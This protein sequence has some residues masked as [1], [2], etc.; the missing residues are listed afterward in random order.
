MIG[1]TRRRNMKKGRRLL[2][3][4]LTFLF[5]T[6]LFTAV[7]FADSY[8]FKVVGPSEEPVGTIT[9]TA[10]DVTYDGQA[11]M[12]TVSNTIANR[13]LTNWDD[14]IPTDGEYSEGTRTRNPNAY[15]YAI[16]PVLYAETASDGLQTEEAPVS[17]GSYSATVTVYYLN[18]QV[19]TSDPS[20]Y[21]YGWLPVGSGTIGFK[22]NKKTV[23]VDWDTRPLTYDGTKQ[24][25]EASYTNAEGDEIHLVTDTVEGDAGIRAGNHR[26]AAAF[27]AEDENA[28]NYLLKNSTKTTN[29][30][31]DPLEVELRWYRPVYDPATGE[32]VTSDGAVELQEVEEDETIGMVYNAREQKPFAEV[33]NAVTREGSTDREIVNVIVGVVDGKTPVKA[34]QYDVY[35]SRL[36]GR[37]SSNYVLSD[38][39]R[40]SVRDFE[41]IPRPVR[42]TWG[43]NSEGKDKKANVTD[44]ARQGYDYWSVYNGRTQAAFIEVG[45]IPEDEDGHAA[46][47]TAAPE[48]GSRLDYFGEP[49]KREYIDAGRYDLTPGTLSDKRNFTYHSISQNTET[50]AIAADGALPENYT[51]T[52]SIV[53]RP[54]SFRWEPL[55]FTYDGQHRQ[56]SAAVTN[57]QKNDDGE[58]DVCTVTDYVLAEADD[59]GQ[60]KFVEKTGDRQLT[61]DAGKYR[62]AVIHLSNRNYSFSDM[63]K[64]E[65]GRWF[66]K[67]DEISAFIDAKIAE[68]AWDKHNWPQTGYRIFA[69]PA[70]IKWTPDARELTYDANR[71]EYSAEVTNLVKKRQDT[72][73]ADVVEPEHGG[74]Y[75]EANAGSYTAKVEDLLGSD[76]LSAKNYTL[77]A[78]E[79]DGDDTTKVKD[80]SIDWKINKKD[81]TVTVY[82]KTGYYGDDPATYK[83]GVRYTGLVNGDANKDDENGVP[84]TYDA[85]Q[86]KDPG[87]PKV[88]AVVEGTPE[89]SCK[90]KKYG[91]PGEYT[92]KAGGL[93]SDNYNINFVNGTLTI[94]NRN[95]AG[96]LVAK[97]K[98]GNRKGTISWKKVHGAAKYQIY[99]SLCNKGKKK[100]TPKLYKTVSAG[101][102]S[103][104]VRKLKKNTYYKFYIVA[105]DSSGKRLART[106]EHHFCTND[107]SGRFTNPKSVKASKTKVTIKKGGKY[108]VKTTVAKVKSN[109]RLTDGTH[110][111][112][113]RY[114]SAAAP[115]ATVSK[116]GTIKGVETGWCRVYTMGAN[117]LWQVIEVT[118]E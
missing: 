33:S 13:N 31:I 12:I 99:F 53:P 109:K 76:G 77:L 17:A 72:H 24:V 79:I 29:Y 30:T 28:S 11:H 114:R 65:D 101:K 81:L 41:I 32:P 50:G 44:P 97:V 110:T 56:P 100:L 70:E 27:D 19:K 7:S 117:G 64:D 61:I 118:V 47:V 104:T 18:E 14:S 10:S 106:E 107:V 40:N 115:V 103:Y 112:K 49:V 54:V 25:P 84:G 37:D 36:S 43:Y 96:D 2:T 38:N 86:F 34:G 82:D 113:V 60:V 87:D 1:K 55:K 8:D 91:K 78:K 67:D 108:K 51:A 98:A 9:L 48:I 35:A 26:A 20:L 63:P 57:L 83:H 66:L 45:N 89:Y 6:G 80:A 39:T 102:K 111:Q 59:D 71:H 21:R 46:E 52:Y 92:I 75:V 3:A 90:Y 73:E 85:N 4:A 93:T 88:K 62:A 58:E 22:I 116:N 42:L 74:T 68:N 16:A 23:D 94:K 105:L 15:K 69:R 95:L 5:A